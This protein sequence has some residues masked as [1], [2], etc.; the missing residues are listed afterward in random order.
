MRVLI[1]RPQPDADALAKTLAARKIKSLVAPLMTIS[2]AASEDIAL[3]GVQALLFTSANGVRAFAALSARRDLPVF[4]VGDATG[5]FAQEVGFLNVA[6][7]GGDVT[8]LSK[9][10]R[11]KLDPAMGAL[12][13]AAGSAIAGDLAGDLEAGG[14]EV[15]RSVLYSAETVSALPANAAKALAQ[16]KIDGV[17]FFSP[18]TART[19]VSL[20]EVAGLAASCTRTTAYCLS[21]AV[22][23]IL[24]DAAPEWGAIRVAARPAQE[25]LLELIGAD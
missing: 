9:L 24:E 20:L 2:M 21:A 6:S 8:D 7:A 19:F 15:R 5:R 17:L 23:H 16:G 11:S 13:H 10:V 12:F 3:D 22:A 14:F 4:A 18:R 1:T 25:A